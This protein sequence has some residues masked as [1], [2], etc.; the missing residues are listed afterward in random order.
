MHAKK[1]GISEAIFSALIFQQ[2]KLRSKSVG[3][4]ALPDSERSACW[5]IYVN[6][7][8]STVVQRSNELKE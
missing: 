4:I 5:I 7:E 6:R 1:K 2:G 8:P 3:V